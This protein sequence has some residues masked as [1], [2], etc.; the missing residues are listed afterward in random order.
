MSMNTH[1]TALSALLTIPITLIFTSIGCN[2]SIKY[3]SADQAKYLKPTVAVMSFENRAP[4]RGRWELGSGLADE[5]IDRLM[6]TNRYNVLKR[7][8]LE[9]ILRGLER[10]GGKK[11][12]RQRGPEMGRL[13]GVRYLIEGAITDF[14]H[15]EAVSGLG[16][17]IGPDNYSIVAVTIHVTDVQSGQVIASSDINAKTRITDVEAKD[18]SKTMAFGSY[19]F[20]KTPLGRATSKMLD[21]AVRQIA[22]AIAE[23]PFQPKIASVINNRIV[24]NGGKDR[25]M[26]VGDQ[27]VV[28][29]IPQKVLDPDTGQ[30]L[31]HIAGKPVGWVRIV[32]VTEKLSIAE[33]V[34]GLKTTGKN[35]QFATGQALFKSDLQTNE[36]PTE[37]S[38]Y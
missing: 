3:D 22:K 16:A 26:K 6:G 21:K 38:N 7:Q 31:G 34:Y 10:T 15:I 35:Q 23:Q 25:K 32:Q 5:L 11:N 1:K 24:I 14:N 27:Y 12:R 4:A 29:S 20:Y 37:F 33:P 13:K 30:L 2:S 9:A 17:L 19:S 8:Q 18:K 28:R 36:K